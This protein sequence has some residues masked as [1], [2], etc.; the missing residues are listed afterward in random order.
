[1]SEGTIISS[2]YSVVCIVVCTTAIIYFEYVELSSLSS[3]SSSIEAEALFNSGWWRNFSSTNH[4]KLRGI[5]C[6]KA[7]SVTRITLSSIHGKLENM[8]WSSLPTLEY[9]NLRYCQLTGSIPDN[10]GT[11]SKLTYLDLSYNYKLEGTASY[12]GKP[13]PISRHLHI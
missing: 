10:I 9:L 5:T 3:F 8:N 6:N 1:M 13:H 12:I 2:V 11:L 4:C 7:G